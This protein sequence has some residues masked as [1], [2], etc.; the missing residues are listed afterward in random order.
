MRKKNT[1]THKDSNEN[2]FHCLPSSSTHRLRFAIVIFYSQSINKRDGVLVEILIY[3][4]TTS[5][6]STPY[7]TADQGFSS[8]SQL[9]CDVNNKLSHQK[10]T[11]KE[12]SERIK[13]EIAKKTES[14][15]RENI[16]NEPVSD[17]ISKYISAGKQ[18]KD[19]LFIA[20]NYCP[21]NPRKKK[22]EWMKERKKESNVS[23]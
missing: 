12:I 16:I 1:H 19:D 18:I 5:I 4:K 15:R 3:I 22:N 21:S 9:Q 8:R 2:R 14:K 20:L 10:M 11:W 13:K 7:L 17:W 23:F 6:R